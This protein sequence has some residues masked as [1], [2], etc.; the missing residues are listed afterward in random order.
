[1][2]HFKITHFHLNNFEMVEVVFYSKENISSE[3][4][5]FK[6]INIY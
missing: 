2:T 6:E 3:G 4:R 5:V 1:M